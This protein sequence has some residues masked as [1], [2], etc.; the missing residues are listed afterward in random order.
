[1]LEY[2]K[3]Q[4]KVDGTSMLVIAGC[5]LIL[6]LEALIRRGEGGQLPAGVAGAA[7]AARAGWMKLQA[8][9]PRARSH[10]KGPLPPC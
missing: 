7:Y 5:F 2:H 6:S 10:D 8:P 4:S 1:M 9:V 3:I